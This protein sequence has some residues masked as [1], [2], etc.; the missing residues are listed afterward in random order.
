MKIKRIAGILLAVCLIATAVVFSVGADYGS[1]EEA[2]DTRICYYCGGQMQQVS[3]C[4]I[5]MCWCSHTDDSTAN[6]VWTWGIEGH[7]GH[8]KACIY[9]YATKDYEAH[10][11]IT[12]NGATYCGSCG[13]TP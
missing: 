2:A 13:Y 9:C 1:S 3:Q 8:Y 5:Y 6:H 4:G 7:L 11:Y 10:G 12:V